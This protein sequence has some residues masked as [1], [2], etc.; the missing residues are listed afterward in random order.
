MFE[1]LPK[2]LRAPA[3][4]LPICVS[5]ISGGWYA[6]KRFQSLESRLVRIE[7]KVNIVQSCENKLSDHSTRLAVLESKVK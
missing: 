4:I 6:G 5:L 1:F 2:N 7:E 3:T